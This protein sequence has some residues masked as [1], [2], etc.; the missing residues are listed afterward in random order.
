MLNAQ[1]TAV[2][3][4]QRLS[5]RVTVTAVALAAACTALALAGF[6]SAKLPV[7]MFLAATAGVSSW[8]AP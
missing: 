3:D 5:A 4:G 1:N 7:L 2:N 6:A 8:A